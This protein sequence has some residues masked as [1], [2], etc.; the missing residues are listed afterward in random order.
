MKKVC[1]LTTVH[2]VFDNRIFYKQARTLNEAGYAVTL[3]AQHKNSEVIEGINII[4][5]PPAR[6][7]LYRIFVTTLRCFLAA[8]KQDCSVYH[9]HDPELLPYGVLLKLITGKKVI[10]D[11]HE[12]YQK[13]ILGK[14][15]L[16]NRFY[17]L[18]AII[19]V[20]AL[21]Y[22]TQFIFDDI[23]V[24]N[25]EQSNRFLNSKT[26]S[27]GNFPILKCIDT[28]VPQQVVKTKPIIVYAGGLT[29]IR[30]IGEIIQA[31]GLLNGK[32]K[33]WF[34]GKWETEEFKKECE[35]FRGWSYTD[36][37]GFFKP[38]D[39]YS[40]LK[41][42]DI[43]LVLFHSAY[44]HTT[45]LPNKIFEY[46]ACGLPVVLSD[47]AYWKKLFDGY[48][49]F[50]NSYEPKEIAENIEH[51]LKDNDLRR[52][53]SER[54]RKLIERQYTWEEEAK[55]LLEIYGREK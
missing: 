31:I 19:V 35:G 26:T 46:M 44:H 15:W 12:D 49:L 16:G 20:R 32:A 38:E 4:A 11:A 25:P 37:L 21:E 8:V 54:G 50:A 51:L 5:L 9:F 47:F 36:Y 40:Y 53:L 27:I 23:I 48:A 45:S 6:N 28:A 34:L 55:K 39:V 13:Q 30:G 52:K 3:I 41:K 7:R 1:I 14:Q 43:G 33:L 10:Y 17:K 22:L 2:W 24:A 18:F 42:A 29:K